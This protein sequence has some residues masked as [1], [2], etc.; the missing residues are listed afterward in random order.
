[1]IEVSEKDRKLIAALR[2]YGVSLSDVRKV[3]DYI[4]FLKY[5]HEKFCRELIKA[6]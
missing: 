3:I 4:E 2:H 1:M 6:R 5:N